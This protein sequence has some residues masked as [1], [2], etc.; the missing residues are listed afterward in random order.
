MIMQTIEFTLDEADVVREI[1][2]HGRRELDLELSRADSFDF[3]TMLRHRHELV[4]QVLEKLEHAPIT[5]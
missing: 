1:L 2:E 4:D 5:I 3:K